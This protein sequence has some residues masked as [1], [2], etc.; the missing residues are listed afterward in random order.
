MLPRFRAEYWSTSA[1]FNWIRKTFADRNKPNSMTIEG[2]DDWETSYK[3]EHPWVYWIVEDFSHTL[4]NFVMYPADVINHI[5]YQWILTWYDRKHVLPTGLPKGEWYDCDTRILH[6]LFETLVDFIE[7]EKAHM[8]LISTDNPPIK[9][10]K[11]KWARWKRVRSRE[12]GIKHLEWEMSLDGPD[13]T[14]YES[15]PSQAAAARE[16]Y[17]LYIWWKD[18]RPNRPDPYDVSG[19]SQWCESKK[20]SGGSWRSIMS[21]TDEER[22]QSKVLMDKLHE[23][24]NRYLQEDEENIIRLIKI[25]KTLWT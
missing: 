17:N 21:E 11:F 18:V 6:G 10:Y 2:W 23:I 22:A 25:R 5:R 9:W 20:E 24:E 8:M 7:I 1:P 3:K 13:L 19:W 14:E 15:C 16:Q 4:Q 12:L